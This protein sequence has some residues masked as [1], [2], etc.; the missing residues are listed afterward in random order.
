M[1]GYA[2]HGI[3]REYPVDGNEDPELQSITAILQDFGSLQRLALKLSQ[4]ARD[5][6]VRIVGHGLDLVEF[7]SLRRLLSHA[8]SDFV[9]EYFTDAEQRRIPD[10]AHR[11]AHLAGQFAAKEAVTKALGTGFGDGVAFGDVEINRTDEGAPLVQLRGEAAARAKA[12]GIDAWFVSISH[13][14]TAAIASAIAVAGSN[15]TG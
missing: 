4:V 7:E 11:L 10:G 1:A 6:D 3:R 15:S 2:S 8:E 13:G 12:S 14:D 5:H 9:T